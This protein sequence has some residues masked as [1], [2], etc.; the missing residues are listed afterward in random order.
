MLTDP[1]RNLALSHDRQIRTA[2]PQIFDL[3]IGMGTRDDVEAHIGCARL[4]DEIS[5]LERIRNGADQPAR[6]GDVCGLQQAG[7]SGIPGDHLDSALLQLRNHRLLLF[8]DEVGLPRTFQGL[9]NH[10]PYSA[11][12]DE[13][14]MARKA[15]AGSHRRLGHGLLDIRLSLPRL[16]PRREPCEHRE[17]QRVHQDRKDRAC[18]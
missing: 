17:Q 4:L 6:A 10:A 1:A 13:H 8:D 18:Q 14:G 16:Q 12:T 5:A 2:L 9:R 3:G 7:L 11:V 15:S